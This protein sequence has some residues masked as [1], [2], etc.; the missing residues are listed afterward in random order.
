MKDDRS[1]SGCISYKIRPFRTMLLG[2]VSYV[3]AKSAGRARMVTARS[4]YEAGFTS[5]L[6]PAEVHCVRAY[7]YDHIATAKPDCCYG[8]KYIPKA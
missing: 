1:T 6:N 4:A 7:E 8:E 5:R 3:W 2:I